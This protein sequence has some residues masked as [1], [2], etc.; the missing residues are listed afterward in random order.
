RNLGR[1]H[2]C[3]GL[4]VAY[5]QSSECTERRIAI[6]ALS[7]NLPPSNRARLGPRTTRSQPAAQN[8]LIVACALWR[9][10]YAL[11]ARPVIELRLIVVPAEAETHSNVGV[12]AVHAILTVLMR[13]PR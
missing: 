4:H 11:R 5:W 2:T 10:D 12:R 8:E 9:Q 13:N 7:G 6:E 3:A 1:W